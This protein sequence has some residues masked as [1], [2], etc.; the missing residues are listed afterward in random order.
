LLL[1]AARATALLA[2]RRGRLAEWQ[3]EGNRP[4]REGERCRTAG[5]RGGRG[6]TT[7]ASVGGRKEG[8][9]AWACSP[10]NKRKRLVGTELRMGHISWARHQSLSHSLSLSLDVSGSHHIGNVRNADRAKYFVRICLDRVFHSLSH[11]WAAGIL[12][13][14]IFI[15][16]ICF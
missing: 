3:W 10:L 11:L 2:S 6:S 16:M 13:V 1:G 4:A 9:R 7:Y 12:F 8:S 15:K 5:A 14:Y